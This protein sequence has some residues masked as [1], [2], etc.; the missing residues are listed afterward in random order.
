[1]ILLAQV[2]HVSVISSSRHVYV[3]FSLT[4]SSSLSTST[5]SSPSVL[6]HCTPTSTTWTP[7]KM[8]CATPP[9][10]ATT[11]RL[12]AVLVKSG[13]GL[14]RLKRS[15]PQ[16]NDPGSAG[17]EGGGEV[18]GPWSTSANFGQLFF[19]EFGQFRLRPI[20]GC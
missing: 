7:W 2:V 12:E 18:C 13:I 3:R 6:M 4:S 14:K 1:M 20:S 15:L 5:C 17:E 19:F 9:R 8:T 11:H 10:G 16:W